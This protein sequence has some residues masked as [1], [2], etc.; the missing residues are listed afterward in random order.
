MKGA[1]ICFVLMI[2]SS[3]LSCP[4]LNRCGAHSDESCGSLPAPAVELEIK[5]VKSESELI[6]IDLNIPVI[7]GCRINSYK[8]N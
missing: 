1:T 8:A 2:P 3:G 7:K 4:G 5:E 6:N